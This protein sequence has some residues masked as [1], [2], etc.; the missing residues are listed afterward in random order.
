MPPTLTDTG[1][2]LYDSLGP[3]MTK[4]AANGYAGQII[5]GALATMVDQSAY[6]ARGVE[7][8]PGAVLFDVNN[9][10]AS[11]LPWLSQFVGDSSAVQNATDAATQRALIKTPANFTRGRPSTFVAVA[12]P[13]LTGTKTVIVN[14]NTGSN[15]WTLTIATYTSE[16]PNP[17]VT[18]NA[19]LSV[20]PAWLVP[21]ITTVNG[22]D[23]ATLAA[24]HSTY[25]LMEAAHTSYTDVH[26]NPG[27]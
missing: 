24:S 23:Y 6:F 14:Q 12:Q 21:T 7:G 10:D 26:A 17:S 5:S 18:K 16:T 19:I 2:R 25:T 22:G 27:A 20:M 15:P 4:D 13:T 8:E 9:V 11:W 1:Q 3:L